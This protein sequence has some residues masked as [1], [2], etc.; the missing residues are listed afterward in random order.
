MR[1]IS[2]QIRGCGRLVDAKVNLDSKIIAI[3][4]PN[5]SGKT[6]FLN[7]LARIDS[8]EALPVS[9]R[10]RAGEGIG[11]STH[12]VSVDFMLDDEDRRAVI[13]LDLEEAPE[14]M[15]VSRR[16]EGGN[17]HCAIHPTPRNNP[18]RLRMY[19][20]DLVRAWAEPI[21]LDALNPDV[22]TNE[23]RAG[24]PSSLRADFD[25]LIGQLEDVLNGVIRSDYTEVFQN[26]QSFLGLFRQESEAKP[27][28]EALLGVI[29]WLERE[30]PYAEVREILW[31]RSPYFLLF[32]EEERTLQSTYPLNDETVKTPPPALRNLVEV[33]GLRLRELQGYVNADDVTRRDTAILKANSRLAEIFSV[34]KQSRL[35]VRMSMDG[36]VLRISVW[37]DGDNITVFSERSAGL[38]MFVALTCFLRR[39]GSDHPPILLIDEAENHLHIDAQAD[40]VDMLVTQEQAA[41]VIYTTHSPACLPP[42]LG[43]SIRSVVPKPN[44]PQVSEIKNSFWQGAAG[45]SPL[46]LAMG[47]AAAAFTPARRVVLAEGATEMI[48]LPSLMREAVQVENLGYQVAPGLSEVPK[49]FYPRLDL[50]AAKV[51][52]LVDGDA[53][54]RSLKRNLV[55]AGV[56]ERLIVILEAP[57]IENTVEV[58]SYRDAVSSLLVE[59]NPG[60]VVPD[61]PDLGEAASEPWARD[62]YRWI[63]RQGLR[64]PSKVAVA[65]RIV[66]SGSAKPSAYGRAL[67]KSVHT[68]LV[69]ALGM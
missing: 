28:T 55:K 40:L 31:S 23:I 42:D 18:K 10:S 58:D 25:E 11:N 68:E 46:M 39:H 14:T 50:E 20:Q 30:D 27:L 65:N 57:G 6:T 1:L 61:L 52:Y 19:M 8:S 43:A 9:Q 45:F 26:C 29:Q 64:V 66:E 37:E 22:V 15:R 47:A 44:S 32:G 38:R 12:Y 5:E 63:E 33:A 53:G 54:G 13:D 4:G 7:S 41:K 35:A 67:L 49:D 3:V 36:G 34:W 21:P 59:S 56:P 16:A 69:R 60:V 62:L 48:L 24:H 2:A 51:A 17:I